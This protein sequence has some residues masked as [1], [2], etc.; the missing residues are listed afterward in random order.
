M[1]V[2]QKDIAESLGVSTVTVSRAL[3]EHA[4]LS[5]ETKR[6]VMEAAE[7]MGYLKHRAVRPAIRR[8]GILAYGISRHYFFESALIQDMFES[9]QDRF[10]EAGVE[11]V[12]QM[13]EPLEVPSMVAEG[14][15]NAV[16][17]MGHPDESIFKHLNN[18]YSIAVAGATAAAAHTHIGSDDFGGEFDITKH[19]IGLGHRDIVFVSEE[20]SDSPVMQNRERGYTVAMLEDNLKPR[21]ARLNG[22]SQTRMEQ[23]TKHLQKWSDATAIACCHDGT[24]YDTLRCCKKLGIDVPG[25]TSIV[26]YDDIPISREYQITTYRPEWAAIGQLAAELI[27]KQV[28]GPPNGFRI[29]VPGRMIHRQTTAPPVPK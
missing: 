24:A 23:I 14:S 19:L 22:G 21:I 9:V 4:D 15:V 3:R 29:I 1:S 2:T 25:G 27:L 5:D 13:L 16:I 20:R 17:L 12:V 28:A 10:R 8:V 7:R 26:G 18:I 11:V 6:R